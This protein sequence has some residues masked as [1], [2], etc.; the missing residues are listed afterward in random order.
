MSNLPSAAEIID[1]S[2]V[3]S[4]YLRALS[5]ANIGSGAASLETSYLREIADQLEAVANLCVTLAALLASASESK[6]ALSSQ[7][8]ERNKNATI[9]KAD[10]ST[11]RRVQREA[12]Q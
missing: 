6:Q 7:A 10:N 12:L 3:M 1:K 5:T 9:F 2:G 11:N 8:A 4:H